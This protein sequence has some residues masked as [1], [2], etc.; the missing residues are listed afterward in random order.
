MGIA[1]SVATT[2][3]YAERRLRIDFALVRQGLRRGEF[4][5]NWV[6]SRA[7]LSYCLTKESDNDAPRLRRTDKQKRPLLVTLLRNCTNLRGV[8]KV[9]KTQ[10]RSSGILRLC[11]LA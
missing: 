11:L 5:L 1:D 6:P 7:N 9:I 3:M 8:R 2:K 10:G 4:V